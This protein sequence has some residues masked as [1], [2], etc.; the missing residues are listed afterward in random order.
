MQCNGLF[1][2]FY[3][4]DMQENVFFFFFDC[5]RLCATI[6]INTQVYQRL[7]TLLLCLSHTGTLA[8][9]DELGE[10]YDENVLRWQCNLTNSLMVGL[11]VR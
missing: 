8:T 2:L 10:N 7:H 9:L 5:D 4:E 6:L 3:I 11:Y 1:L